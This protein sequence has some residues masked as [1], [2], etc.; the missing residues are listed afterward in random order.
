MGLYENWL[1]FGDSHKCPFEELQFVALTCQRHAPQVATWALAVSS[2]HSV[3]FQHRQ[4]QWL[5]R[6]LSPILTLHV[7]L[8][9]TSHLRSPPPALSLPSAV[10]ETPSLHPIQPMGWT[11]QCHVHSPRPLQRPKP[12]DHSLPV[13]CSQGTQSLHL[14]T[15]TTCHFNC[16]ELKPQ[17]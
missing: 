1:T 5:Y 14:H 17:H 7:S 13:L 8:S 9:L 4:L 12:P 6:S 15:L 3:I 16:V 2:S 10:A 11:L